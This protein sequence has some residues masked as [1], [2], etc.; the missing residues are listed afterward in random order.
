MATTDEFVLVLRPGQDD[1]AKCAGLYKRTLATLRGRDM[2]FNTP[3]KRVIFFNGSTWTISTTDYLV[4][5]CEGATGGFYFA[6]DGPKEPYQ[7]N[8]SP[9]YET[10]YS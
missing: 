9:R 2:W 10:K 7:A 8:W 1:Y 6:K 3:K 4:T 5:I